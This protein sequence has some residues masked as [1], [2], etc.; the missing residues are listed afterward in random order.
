M[1]KAELKEEP[2]GNAVA[3]GGVDMNPTGKPVTYRAYDKRTKKDKS[4]VILKRF[5]AQAYSDK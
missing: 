4:P 5:I 1:K 2:A 3:Q